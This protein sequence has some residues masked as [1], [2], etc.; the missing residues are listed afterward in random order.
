MYKGLYI[1]LSGA[2]LKQRH[3]DIFAQNMANANTTGYKKERIS[4]RDFMIPVDNNP[5]MVDDGR[6]MSVVSTSLTD[7]SPGN[8][9]KTGNPLDIAIHGEGFFALEDNKYTRNG[10]FEVDSE[11]YLVTHDG[12]K[13]LGDGGPIAIEGGKIDI[14]SSGEVFVNDVPVGTLKI[15]DFA[16]KSVLSKL[17]GGLFST[18]ETPEPVDARVNQGFIEESNVEVLR[19]M[20][21][22]I[23]ALRE[24]EAYQKM[25]RTFDEAAS[26]TTNDLT[27]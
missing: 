26:Q 12:M 9:V 2:L 6:A 27:K 23:N 1:A 25:I 10:S 8:Q 18:E 17:S 20:V 24:F 21:K 5:G 3:M 22:M 13:V 16:D 19:E 4:F 7:F 15:V 14:N 11:G